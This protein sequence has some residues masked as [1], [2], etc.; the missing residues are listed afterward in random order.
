MAGVDFTTILIGLGASG[1]TVLGAA[2]APKFK[3]D[4]TKIQAEQAQT[5][6]E[7]ER[8]KLVQASEDEF[9]QQVS[10]SR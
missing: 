5:S 3:R 7:V 9:Q 4:E 1:L 2:F 6:V 10:S 8:A